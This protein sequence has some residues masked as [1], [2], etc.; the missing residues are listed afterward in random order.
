M[1][2]TTITTS[3]SGIFQYEGSNAR[4][5]KGNA[6]DVFPTK[7]ASSPRSRGHSQIPMGV[8]RWN[9]SLINVSSI[10]R[11]GSCSVIHLA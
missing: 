5:R 11:I 4:G 9:Q 8:G 6:N 1:T 2:T 3:D 10:E 7:L